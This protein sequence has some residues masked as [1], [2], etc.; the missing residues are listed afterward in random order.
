MSRHVFDHEAERGRSFPTG[1]AL[2][3]L[4]VLSAVGTALW[5]MT[6]P[7]VRASAPADADALATNSTPARKATRYQLAEAS[8]LVE[9]AG[10]GKTELVA[11]LLRRGVDAN[12]KDATGRS[13]LS[14]AVAAG[15][16]EAA[17]ELLSAGATLARLSRE[18]GSELHV[19]VAHDDEALI[20]GLVRA[21]AALDAPASALDGA[22]ALHVASELGR[23]H[24][25]AALIRAKADIDAVDAHG[26]TPL[27]RATLLGRAPIVELLVRSGA[28]SHRV[29]G[30]RRTPLHHAAAAGDEESVRLLLSI[31]ADTRATDEFGWTALHYAAAHGRANLIAPLAKAMPPSLLDARNSRGATALHLAARHGEAACVL[32]LLDAGLDPSIRDLDG[33]RARDLAPLEWSDE[34]WNRL[35]AIPPVSAAHQRDPALLDSASRRPE[36]FV[37][38]R[39]AGAAH[40]PLVLLDL[41]IWDDGVVVFAPWSADGSREFVAGVL[42]P[43]LRECVSRDLDETGWLDE[44]A[45]RFD[46]TGRD[47]VEIAI[48]R[49]GKSRRTAWD[50]VQRADMVPESSNRAA[51]AEWSLGWARARDVLRSARPLT[52]Q[53]MSFV[54]VR[55]SFRGLS[56]E[57][58]PHA[59]WM[60]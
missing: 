20:D 28:D 34:A 24:A 43:S 59:S 60:D 53:A 27:A 25:V 5:R 9:A 52:T 3:T 29:D 30:K 35:G 14:A 45:P 1:L 26:F 11:D 19:A 16:S 39:Q 55:G 58:S 50:E 44:Q 51:L 32:A 13:A 38:T 4:L 57:G 17:L 21:G 7:E 37:C 22:T 18:R 6:R 42:A 2:V 36:V 48:A 46:R 12:A 54:A 33:R 8:S 31:H 49:D 10:A 41:A 47:C 40:D 56:F 23:E 15:E